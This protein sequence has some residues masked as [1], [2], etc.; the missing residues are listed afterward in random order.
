MREDVETSSDNRNAAGY[1]TQEGY[2][3]QS[4][5]DFPETIWLFISDV[6]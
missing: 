2:N 3:F 5:W 6:V 1:S 4:Q